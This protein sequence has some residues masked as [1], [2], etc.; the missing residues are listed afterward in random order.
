MRDGTNSFSLCHRAEGYRLVARAHPLPETLC[1]CPR[2]ASVQCSLEAAARHNDFVRDNGQSR[3][4]L[5]GVIY[6]KRLK[7]G[8]PMVPAP[9]RSFK[10][11][12]CSRGPST[13]YMSGV[14]YTRCNLSSQ[15]P[16]EA[17]LATASKCIVLPLVLPAPGQSLSP[18][19]EAVDPSPQK[20]GS[21]QRLPQLPP[22]SVGRVASRRALQGTQP[23][24]ATRS[25]ATAGLICPAALFQRSLRLGALFV[26][27]CAHHE[28]PVFMSTKMSVCTK[29]VGMVF[30]TLIHT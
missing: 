9:E 10:A 30:S 25:G 17:L 12:N 24:R 7:K 15:F 11:W 29:R 27:A 2:A 6:S 21:S 19:T 4:A 8:R 3:G 14:S 23:K 18:A 28:V 5:I 16:E 1:C 22:L 20:K 26:T 13:R